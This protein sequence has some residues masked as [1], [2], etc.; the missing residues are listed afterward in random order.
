[1][2]NV[3]NLSARLLTALL[4]VTSAHAADPRASS[5]SMERAAEMR[6]ETN[7]IRQNRADGR[8]DDWRR[9]S[10]SSVKQPSGTRTNN[11]SRSPQCAE[12]MAD[13]E[14]AKR[15]RGDLAADMAGRNAASA[16]G[17][18]PYQADQDAKKA[19]RQKQAMED[20]RRIAKEEDE[21]RQSSSRT[22]I[23]RCDGSGCWGSDG[24]R[25]NSTRT[26]GFVT[27][28]GRPCQFNGN[29]MHCN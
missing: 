13:Y 26:G 24:N 21:G 10:V 11:S 8:P 2:L 19:A 14:H 15:N 22:P 5:E 3:V 23:S 12:K 9:D 4:L 7:R 6:A 16:C 1:M 20:G 17:F 27:N 28:E 29:M 25:Y 18:N